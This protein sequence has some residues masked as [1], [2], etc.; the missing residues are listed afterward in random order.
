[1][2]TGMGFPIAV[3]HDFVAA[4]EFFTTE[5]RKENRFLMAS[6]SRLGMA[7]GGMFRRKQAEELSTARLK[8]FQTLATLA[9]VGI[10]QTDANGDCLYVND[11]WCQLAGMT[12]IEAAGRGWVGA[13]HPDD[14]DRVFHE[15]YEAA[16][17][18]KEFQS[19]YRFQTPSGKV[20]WLEGRATALRDGDGQITGYLGTVSD[21]TDRKRSE[22]MQRF[23]DEASKVLASS[24]EF[25]LTIKTVARLAV[26]R[27]G[28]WCLV[29]L[30]NE[31]GSFERLAAAH[32]EPEKEKLLVEM[33]QRYPPK[34]DLKFGLPN[35]LRT[36]R[37]EFYSDIPDSMLASAAYDEHH[38]ELIRAIGVKSFLCVPLVVSGKAVGSMTFGSGI[39]NRH[40]QGDLPIAEELARRSGAAIEN[41]RL[42]EQAREAIRARD[43]F[44]SIASHELKTPLTSQQLHVNSRV[45]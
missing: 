13:L 26:P 30:Q 24:L 15:W 34:S 11:R 4:L 5:R 37:S 33:M 23:L 38:L 43:E 28:E 36:G 20:S 1:M 32:H 6:L 44:L 21:I 2:V 45:N 7:L 41:A 3:G 22:E 8:S 19:E 31:D 42:Y 12:R 29:A 39:P 16:A 35:V 14:R 17:Q 9:P 27:L 10:F 18:G 40:G 25:E